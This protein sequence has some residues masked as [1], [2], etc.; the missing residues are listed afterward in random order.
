LAVNNGSDK[1]ED[2][3]LTYL[4]VFTLDFFLRYLKNNG[5]KMPKNAAAELLSSSDY[6]FTLVGGDYITRAGV[7]TGRW[8]SF[9]PSKE[10]IK[11][12]HIILGH[13]CMPFVNPEIAPDQITLQTARKIILSDETSFSMNLAMDVYALYGEGYV[14]PYLFNDSANKKQTISSLQYKSLPSEITLTSWPLDEIIGKSD[15]KYG[16]RLLC[17]VVDWAATFVEISVLKNES[18]SE[19][20]KSDIQR[21]E[22]Y[23]DFENSFLASFEKNGPASSIEE[24]LAFLYLENT[25]ELCIENCGSAEE[26]LQHTKKI[27]FCPYGVESRIWRRG[28]TV[29][30]IG[31]WNK[32]VTCEILYSN[33]A[34]LF[35]HEVID[36]FLRQHLYDKK[37]KKSQQ[38]LEDLLNILYPIGIKMLPRERKM[39]LTNLEARLKFMEAYNVSFGSQEMV[40]IRKRV[41]NLFSQ[42]INL[43][44]SIAGSGLSLDL[45]PQQELII[46][47]QLFNHIERIIEELESVYLAAKLPLDDISLSLD[48]MEDTFE[49]ICGTLNNSL[50]VNTYNNIKIVEADIEN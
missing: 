20:S 21:E 33:I 45:F 44:C 12:R 46:L 19:I 34:L 30:F 1:I 11:K 36:F 32:D 8:F 4:D 37:T 23:S 43:M 2:F 42:V 38:T 41:V 22:W 35:S 18:K 17:R 24:Q 25:R 26:F 49:E 29:P 7:F 14:L 3:L 28:E 50:E 9:K 47:T 6:V 15:F 40:S 48:G 16:D 5:I 27:A 39:I 31:N 10:E 13:R